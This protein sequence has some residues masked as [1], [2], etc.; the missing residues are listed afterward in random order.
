MTWKFRRLFVLTSISHSLATLNTPA[1]TICPTEYLTKSTGPKPWLPS[2][3]RD[4][5][6]ILSHPHTLPFHFGGPSQIY[7][8]PNYISHPPHGQI[9]PPS[10]KQRGAVHVLVP[11]APPKLIETQ[12]NS[13]HYIFVLLVQGYL[14]ARSRHSRSKN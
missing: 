3:R 11:S 13:A 9:L 4:T 2:L 14:G 5:G 12:Q 1:G 10:T 7:S 8:S 6:L